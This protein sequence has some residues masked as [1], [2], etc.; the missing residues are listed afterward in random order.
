MALFALG[1]FACFLVAVPLGLRAWV[2]QHYGEQMYRHVPDVPARPVAIVFG[3]GYWSSG[4]LSDALADRMDTAIELYEAGQVNKLLLTGDNRFADYNEPAA[5]AA[6]ARER[7]VPEGD[8]VLDY[9]GRR[10]YDSCY[11]AG[12]IFGVER[13]VLITQEFHLPRAL[14]TCDRLG[15]EVTGAIADRHRYARSPWYQVR[16][17]AALARAW[18]D[19]NIT[20]PLPV[21]GDPIPVEWDTRAE[22]RS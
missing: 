21:L 4:R 1:V 9:A 18:I 7:G 11:R 15:L 13:A 16:E 17:V 19:L 14:Y 5:M 3:A 2:R 12:A 10:T 22:N 6:Y 20:R 8:L